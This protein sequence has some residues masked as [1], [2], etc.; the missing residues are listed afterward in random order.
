MN[1]NRARSSICICVLGFILIFVLPCVLQAENLMED[2]FSPGGGGVER[3]GVVSKAEDLMQKQRYS[4]AYRLLQAGP[5]QEQERDYAVWLKALA[6]F[7]S[8]ETAKALQVCL[9]EA[10]TAHENQWLHKIR[11]LTAEIYIQNKD[12]ESA[13][14]LYKQEAIR[15]LSTERKD[16]VA[17]VYIRFA[18]MLSYKPGPDELNV[19]A[20][21]YKKAYTFYKKALE[22]E[23]GPGLRENI[24]FKMARM[25]ELEGAYSQAV[26]EYQQYL[27]EFDPL[28]QNISGSQYTEPKQLDVSGLHC[29][30]AR[31]RLAESYLRNSD[32]TNSREEYEDL[33]ALLDRKDVES[34]YAGD[35]ENK[36]LREKWRKLAMRCIP[37]TYKFPKPQDHRELDAGLEKAAAYLALFP[38]DSL[39]VTIAWYAILALDHQG[40]ADQAVSAIRDF[41]DGKGFKL[42]LTETEE[43]KALREELGFLKTPVEQYEDLQK[44]ALFL[45]GQLLFKQKKYKECIDVY[46]EYTLKFPNGADWTAAQ[47]GILDAEY[48]VG[49]DLLGSKE[50]EEARRVW[51]GFLIKYPLDSRSRQILFTLAMIEYQ[52]GIESKEAGE[53]EKAQSSFKKAVN[54]FKRLISKYPKTEEASLAQF[55]MAEVLEY[56]L[57]DLAEA[58]QAYR[59]LTWGSYSAQA[60]VKVQQMVNKNLLV[61][62]ERVFRTNETV[63]I[64]LQLRNIQTVQLKIYKLNMTDYFHKFHTI[65]GVEYLDLALIAPDKVW[66]VQIQGYKDYLPVEQQIEIPMQGPGMYAVNVSEKDLEATTLVIRSD[67]EILVKSSRTQVLVF[68]QNMRTNKGEG[69][70]DVLITDGSKVL[71]SGKT[72]NDG[73]LLK[74]IEELKQVKDLC[75][76]VNKNGNMASNRLDLSGLGFSKGLAPKGY[77]YTDRPVYRP[78]QIVKLRGIIRDVNEGAYTAVQGMKML[79]AVVDSRGRIIFEGGVSLSRFGTFEQQVPLGTKAAQGTYT[80]RLSTAEEEKVKLNFNG[81]FTV[82]EFKTEKIRLDLEFDKQV[83]FRGETIKVTFKAAYY[84]GQPAAGAELRY[85]LPDGRTITEKTDEQGLLTLVFETTPFSAGSLLVFKGTLL[86][87]NVTTQS[88]VVLAS[89]GFFANVTTKRQVSLAG[90]PV[91]ITVN[92]ADPAGNPV[93]RELE[94]HV[95]VR[96]VEEEDPLLSGIPWLTRQAAP[97]WAEKE[98]KVLPLRTDENGSA[99]ISYTPEQGGQYVFRIQGKD[100]LGNIVSAQT[101][102]M[103]SGQEDKI[104]LRIFTEQQHYRVGDKADIRIISRLELPRL[105]LFTF[106]GEGVITYLL[107]EIKRGENPL[108]FAIEHEH[109]PNFVV[110]LAI[111][112]GNKLEAASLP[113]T[114]ERKLLVSIKPEQENY[115]PGQTARIRVEVK[116]HQGNPVESEFSLALVNEAIFASYRDPAQDIVSFFQKGAERQTFMRFET[117]CTFFYLPDTRKTVGEFLDE[118]ARLI[119][120]AEKEYRDK[121][122]II[123]RTDEENA[124]QDLG[125]LVAGGEQPATTA[126]D[127]P[128]DVTTGN[129]NDDVNQISEQARKEKMGMEGYW[130]VFVITEADGTAVLDVP[131]PESI[132]AY[133]LTVKGCTRETLVGESTAE[134]KVR[135]D[136]FAELKTPALVQE[137][138]SIRLPATVHNLTDYK[139]PV[140]VS[141][142]LTVAGERYDLKQSVI[143][144]P[145]SA[146]DLVFRSFTIPQGVE[147]SVLL[148]VHAAG[149][150]DPRFSD[151]QEVSIPIR[152][153]GLAFS[154]QKSGVAENDRTLFLKLK[155]GKEYSNLHMDIHVGASLNQELIDFVMGDAERPIYEF[156]CGQDGFPAQE[157]SEALALSALFAY[158]EAK[159]AP[160]E[161]LSRVRKQLIALVSQITSMQHTDGSWLFGNG[162]S[163]VQITC[164][165]HWALARISTQGIL[166]DPAVLKASE[167]YLKNSYAKLDQDDYDVRAMIMHALSKTGA[168][169]YT[170]VNRLYRNRNA[171]S[172]AALAYTALS[173]KALDHTE[174]AQELIALLDKKAIVYEVENHGA[175]DTKDVRYW[176]GKDNQ[177]WERNA[178]ETTALVLLAYEALKPQAEQVQQAVQ[179][180]L[181]IK[182]LYGYTPVKAKGVAV[183]ALSSYYGKVK[184]VKSDYILEILVNDEPVGT[185]KA[186]GGTERVTLHVPDR[187][188]KSGENK[189][190]FKLQGRGE[191]VYTAT[192]SGFSGDLEYKNTL[193]DPHFKDKDY[194][195][196]N[197]TY[198][199]RTV[200]KSTMEISDLEYGKTALVT[201]DFRDY[202]EDNYI[203]LID[204]IPSG[205]VVLKNTITGNF[206]MVQIKDGKL[207]FYF[208]PHQYISAISYQIAGYTPGTYK[209]LPPIIINAQNPA[210]MA[211]GKVSDLSLLAF[212]ENSGKPYQMNK[213]ELFALGKA[214]FDDGRYADA[215]VLLEDL[216]AQDQKYNQPDLARMMLWIRSQEEFYDAEKLVEYFE[217]LKEKYPD[218]FIPFERILIIGRAYHDIGEYERAYIVYRATVEASFLKD[219][220]IGG[221]LEQGGEFYGSMSFL[222]KLW[223]EYPDSAQVIATYFTLAQEIYNKAPEASKVTS[224]LFRTEKDAPVVFE[225]KDFLHAAENLLWRF[226]SVYSGSPLADD[227]AFT[228]INLSLDKKTYETSVE[229]CR[230]YRTVYTESDYTSSFQYMEAL[231]LFSLRRYQEA[232]KAATVVAEGESEDRELAHY[233]LAQIYHT[234]QKPEQAIE[235]YTRV[236]DKYPDAKEAISYFEK[237]SIAMSEVT[238]FKPGERVELTLHYRNISH[239]YFQ[240]YKV[241]LM[242]L[243]LK[244][245]NLSRITHIKLSGISPL[246]E[247]DVDL[248]RG[249][250][251]AD[252]EKTIGLNLRDEGAYLVICRGDDLFTSGLVLVTP[253][254]I[255]V[256]EDV[257]SGRVRVNVK[258]V[259]RNLYAD[260]VHVKVIGSENDS[261]VSGQ[262]DLRG[263]FIADGINGVTTVIVR[264]K[265]DRYA[266]HRGVTLLSAQDYFEEVPDNNE[267]IMEQEY[268]MNLNE[269]QTQMRD[270]NRGNLDQMYEEDR[271]GVQI[272]EAY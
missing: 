4:E 55:R 175:A 115:E 193:D 52:Q 135:K 157:A 91:E 17:G 210:E 87:E 164:L 43:D 95:L 187:I 21:D 250:D 167:T 166:I 10:H 124:Q 159:D 129:L 5:I 196:E 192:L 252:M 251:Y 11:F 9:Q 168:A 31:Y 68:A 230:R 132:T 160:E 1:K 103:V 161:L 123:A 122:E 144:E 134:L 138:D 12:Y 82:E 48:Y 247:K 241:D 153:W 203:I 226:M 32:L 139:G 36:N 165:N 154:D 200:G 58:L 190:Y 212:G 243:Y 14:K 116:D 6:L 183:A 13:E 232:I 147:L 24:R 237:K 201:L 96:E 88:K 269:K 106:E 109:F 79:C 114:V 40:R 215:L 20:P 242:K 45:M 151:A 137:G 171:L 44:K 101:F 209:V 2:P 100:R 93:S 163:A 272:K 158:L 71:F 102:A 72:G 174:M 54:A 152:P 195:H 94:L 213:G 121:K 214:Y 74:N 33:I 130:Q 169:D 240:V 266:F 59:T 38:D 231:G 207:L 233:I 173:L 112:D 208:E 81:S 41:V 221:A 128:V 110:S 265:K 27:A 23:I 253:L 145:H 37:F 254:T 172:N 49:I 126:K 125:G 16:E 78:G 98:L 47:R 28:W 257:T 263:I 83:Y 260:D 186:V 119:R 178:P 202:T 60:K 66:D 69:A 136:F 30:E 84:Y 39:S 155:P 227:A 86:S 246:I 259:V 92:T 15:L 127:M 188:I 205:A 75:V 120:E 258:D 218:L 90:E 64:K 261:F 148:R 67:I 76:F 56:E 162:K 50:Y 239:A 179:Y 206:S 131:L 62:T 244:E 271:S 268:R 25:R 211:I 61:K 204:H 217:V 194:I 198:K 222:H 156:D 238:S 170:Y 229:L 143:M 146:K 108:Q 35:L 267:A 42:N 8:G 177:L 57:A 185:L 191:Y 264:D 142:Q 85:V 216:Y 53:T 104:A 224:R 234:Q 256:Q 219:A 141:A 235:H 97:T 111:M 255:E 199:G 73:V 70:A 181:R 51:E 182:G 236:K 65:R 220:P 249:K 26:R 262:T 3:Q 7:R 225:T 22:L 99:R 270:I 18:E 228:M 189:I 140:E 245:K 107:K 117:S 197:L 113:F 150:T 63:N 34:L 80:I 223:Q 118:E 248:G 77:I 133:R 180:L 19:P 29:A 105:A 176:S 46:T 149:L 184:D 89:F